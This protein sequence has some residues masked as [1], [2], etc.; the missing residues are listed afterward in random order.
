MSKKPSG[1]EYRKRKAD[2]DRED[3]KQAGSF[4][5]Y[6]KEEQ[7]SI[8]SYVYKIGNTE[9][10]DV[11]TV[12]EQPKLISKNSNI[13]IGSQKTELPEINK[14]PKSYDKS[15][16]DCQ[17]TIVQ[18]KDE[19]KSFNLNDISSWPISLKAALVTELVLKGP[20]QNKEGPFVTITRSGAETKGQI[21]SMSS[22]WFYRQLDN[23]ERI[24]RTWMVY[25]TVN[26][27]LYCF[28]CRLFSKDSEQRA[29]IKN[30]FQQWWKLN[31]KVKQHEDSSTHI[32]SFEKWK[33]LEMRIRKEQTIDRSLQDQI[34]KEM[35]IWVKIL[36]RILDLCS[37]NYVS[38]QTESTSP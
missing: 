29:F 31:P 6:L 4:L 18:N 12:T 38:S 26:E 20:I 24:L 33:E 35:K 9:I 11:R 21:R 15:H 2:R 25:S 28:C 32:A 30:G 3:Q 23:G 7:K 14:S 1:A 16:Q 17:K 36:E 8:V 13:I 34:K 22:A 27:S 37:C 5:K 10:D 19:L